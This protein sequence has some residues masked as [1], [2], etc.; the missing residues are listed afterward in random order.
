MKKKILLM[1]V[2][3]FMLV[4]CVTKQSPK[5]EPTPEPEPVQLRTYHVEFESMLLSDEIGKYITIGYDFPCEAVTFENKATVFNKDL[6]LASF[7]F[8]VSAPSKTAINEVYAAY[9]FKNIVNS[10][11]YDKLETKQSVKYTI[12]S[13][14]VGDDDLIALTISGLKYLLPWQSNFD[15][16][17]EGDHKGFT[18]GA[19]KVLEALNEYLKDYP[20]INKRKLWI[21]GY[22]RSAGISQ[23]VS[24]HLLDEELF[25]EDNLYGYFFE[26]PLGIDAEKVGEYKSLFNVINSG[27][28]ITYIPPTN[29]GFKR[30]GID[31]DIYN[32]NTDS[33]VKAFDE[34]LNVAPF[35]ANSDLGYKNEAEFNVFLLEQ[36]T[37]VFESV[38]EPDFHDLS[39]K[40]R[41]VE[42]YQDTFAYLLSLAFSLKLETIVAVK[43]AFEKLNIVDKALLLM[44]K[45]GV[46]N[47]LK[48][49]FDEVEQPYD[50]EKLQT[51]TVNLVTFAQKCT[52]VVSKIVSADFQNVAL[53]S[54]QL[55]APETVLPLLINK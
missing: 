22:S 17:V 29:Y 26:T 38:D 44:D 27:D 46:Y 4:G 15:L 50:D 18:E 24:Y 11:D 20:N 30:I 1:S 23:I 36:L 16:G 41:F 54:V 12:G 48:P 43:E 49:I 55:H 28:L 52:T 25:L 32:K 3:S 2:L 10:P 33:I 7:A 34:R 42:F 31:V 40:D 45:M 53:R 19:N 14:K 5:P 47:F 39:T 6:A 21:T 51:S 37:K 8:N 9:D 13:K 35:K